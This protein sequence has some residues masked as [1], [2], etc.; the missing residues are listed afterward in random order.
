MTNIKSDKNISIKANAKPD[1]KVS[2]TAFEKIMKE[3]NSPTK[4]IEWNGIE[5]TIK[6]TLSFKDVLSFVDN[7]V[8]SCFT[9]DSNSYIP[10]VKEFVIKCCILEMYANFALP[11]NIERKYDLLYCT[12]AVNVVVA[13]INKNQF[14]EILN[15]IDAKIDNIA[16]ANIEAINK[17]MN[18]LYSAFNNLQ[19]QMAGIFA[20]IGTDEISK[21]IGAIA[22]DKF[23]E[24]KLVQAYIDKRNTDS[25]KENGEA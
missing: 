22:G 14:E 3:T 18:E 9:M 6:P 25:A 8:K 7:V 5:V 1:K 2:I 17:Q 23:D 21:L 16:Q 15:A 10:E 24:T 20:G 11:T 4:T 19:E 12:D 13:N